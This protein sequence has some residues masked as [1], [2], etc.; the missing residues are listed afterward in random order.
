MPRYTYRC[1]Q[2]EDIFEIAHSISER[3]KDCEACNTDG[4]LKRIP[5]K[6]N[7][8]RKVSPGVEQPGSIVKKHIEEAKESISEQREEMKRNYI[9]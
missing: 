3:L 2:C 4:S 6:I 1:S 9:P 8:L 5:G 7:V